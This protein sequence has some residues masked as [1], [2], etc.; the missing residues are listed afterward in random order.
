MTNVF[1]LFDDYN[2]QARLYPSLL[3]L[4]PPLLALVAWFPDLLTTN[5]GATLIT[6]LGSCGLLFWLSVFS[7]SRGKLV[8]ARLLKLWGGWPTTLWF[9]YR[10]DHLPAPT[11][12]RYHAALVRRIPDLHL[13]SAAEESADQQAADEFYTDPRLNG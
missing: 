2:R 4:L 7:R 3:T 9:R 10:D 13:P 6:F 11:K 1:G 5:V 12:Q 8:E